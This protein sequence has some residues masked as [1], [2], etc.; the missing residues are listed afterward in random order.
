MP[1]PRAISMV[2]LAGEYGVHKR[3]VANHLQRRGISRRVTGRQMTDNQVEQ[4]K[5]LYADF[6]SLSRIGE[7]F[8][9]DG[10][11]VSTE[12]RKI[13]VAIRPQGVRY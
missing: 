9:V 1:S 12:L 11:V 2:E 7:R 4:A 10:S 8:G 3:T 13:G 5:V 6:V